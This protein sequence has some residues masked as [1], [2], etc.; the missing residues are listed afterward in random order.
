MQM[1]NLQ[2]RM[3]SCTDNDLKKKLKSVSFALYETVL[4]LDGHPDCQAALA[5]YNELVA[6]LEELTE[7]YE[8]KHGPLTIYSNNSDKWD[9]VSSPWPWESEAN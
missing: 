8:Q 9:W 3:S 1:M 2:G 7:K 4:Y 5:H 6:E